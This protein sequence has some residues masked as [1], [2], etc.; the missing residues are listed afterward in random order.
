M[1]ERFD[2]GPFYSQYTDN[3]EPIRSLIGEENTNNTLLKFR[4]YSVIRIDNIE[5]KG[6]KNW[7]IGMFSGDKMQGLFSNTMQSPQY[8]LMPHRMIQMVYNRKLNF[9]KGKNPPEEIKMYGVASDGD[10][11]E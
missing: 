7:L 2:I 8:L 6:L 10:L 9:R 1:L 3:D 4:R 5:K 11:I